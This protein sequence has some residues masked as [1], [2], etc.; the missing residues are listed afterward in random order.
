MRHYEIILMIYPEKSEKVIKIIELYKKIILSKNGRI[1]RLENWG[2]RSLA[3]TIQKLQQAHYI[4]MNIEVSIVCMKYLENHFKF[5]LNI[6]RHLVTICSTAFKEIS[7]ILKNQEE[8]KKELSFS[9]V[10]SKKVSK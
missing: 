3:Y 5:N 6:M 1:H 4:L 2:K 9:K 10:P 8:N 7:V